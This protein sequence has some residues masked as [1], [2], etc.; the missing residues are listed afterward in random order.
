MQAEHELI[1]ASAGEPDR[2]R[3]ADIHRRFGLEIIGPA[4][5]LP[6]ELPGAR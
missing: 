1:L 4:P 3:L 6:R 5:P 2:D